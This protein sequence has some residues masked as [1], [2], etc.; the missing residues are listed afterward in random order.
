MFY[1]RYTLF[2]FF[3]FKIKADAS[4]ILLAI[5][6][7]WTLSSQLFPAHFP[8]YDED[9]YQFMGIVSV[10]GVF[11]SILA[12]ELAHAIIAEHYHMPISGIILYV[13]GGV[14]EM[15]RPPSHPK[16]EFLMAIAGPVMSGFM[17]LFFYALQFLY[18]SFFGP[19]PVS[20]VLAF[21]SAINMLIA[22]FNIMPAFPLDG[23]RALRAAIWKYGGNIVV[24]T[25]VASGLGGL[26]AYLLMAWGCFLVTYRA[27]MVGGIWM[28]LLGIFTL[29][30]G[31]YAVR[32]MESREL[33]NNLHVR[34]FIRTDFISVSPDI[35]VTSLVNDYIYKF[36]QKTFPVTDREK[37]V[38]IVSVHDILKTSRDRWHWIHVSSVMEKVSADT[39][40]PAAMP[41]ADALDLMQRIGSDQ[42]MVSE[43]NKW[44]GVVLLRDILNYVS[45]TYRL[46]QESLLRQKPETEEVEE[47]DTRSI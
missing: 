38:G 6:I 47:A 1:N 42:L 34:R 46:D 27:D 12:H 30:A 9:V 14:A 25:R 19:D 7:S 43:E 31:R 40:V 13:F 11:L 35:T 33:L 8:G 5:F 10:A 24:A 28:G 15:T 17:A 44:V 18:N 37:L 21:L 3:G 20:Q 29:A 41:A 16:G 4:W 26:F 39:S 45:I 36:Y 23:G 32:Q 22:V 2:R